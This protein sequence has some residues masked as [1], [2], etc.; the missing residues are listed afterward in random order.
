M[1]SLLTW[2][3]S[4]FSTV[5]E[6]SKKNARKIYVSKIGF[7]KFGEHIPAHLIIHDISGKSIVI[8]YISG[9][10]FIHDN[11]IGVITNSPKF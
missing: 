8:E 9:K 11:P 3:L 6:V 10:L 4:K 7:A 1:W 2:I 5:E